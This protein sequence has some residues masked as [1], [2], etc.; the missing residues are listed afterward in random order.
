MG[1][2]IDD[3]FSQL[4]RG[5]YWDQQSALIDEYTEKIGGSNDPVVMHA[6][7]M[8]YARRVSWLTVRQYHDWLTEN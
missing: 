1:K 5:A 6:A 7:A 8:E 3:F 4:D 2:N